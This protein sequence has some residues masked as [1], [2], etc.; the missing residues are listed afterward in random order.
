MPAIRSRRTPPSRLPDIGQAE[1]ERAT[2]QTNATA[3]PLSPSLARSYNRHMVS[4]R[5]PHCGSPQSEAARCW[6]CRRS[7]TS[8]KTCRHFRNAVAD[9][10]GYCALDKKRA[11]LTGEEERACWEGVPA[12]A[13]AMTTDPPSRGTDWAAPVRTGEL[14]GGTATGDG[15]DRPAIGHGMWSEPGSA[16]EPA[17]ARNQTGSSIRSRPWGPVPGQ[18]DGGGKSRG[19]RL[20][21]RR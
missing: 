12:E 7:T 21:G 4:W 14:W 2:A 18:T 20:S 9:R 16:R 19:V 15:P 13:S 3:K 10:V 5:C 6:V 11:P 1:G 17:P 8:C